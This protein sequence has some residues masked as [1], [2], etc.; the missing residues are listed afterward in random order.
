MF[1]IEGGENGVERGTIIV[2]YDQYPKSLIFLLA[3]CFLN[4]K[5]QYCLE[6]K[7]TDEELDL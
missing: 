2:T 6:W 4:V 5:S 3:A 7:Y 1:E